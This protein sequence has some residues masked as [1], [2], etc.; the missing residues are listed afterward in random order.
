MEPKNTNPWLFWWEHTLSPEGPRR[1][2]RGAK[3]QR[4]LGSAAFFGCLLHTGGA[5]VPRSSDG[6]RSTM[7]YPPVS[8]MAMENRRFIGDGSIKTSIQFRDFPASHV[9]WN[10]RVS[11]I[12]IGLQLEH[13]KKCGFWERKPSVLGCPDSPMP[14]AFLSAWD[15]LGT[16]EVS[17]RPRLII[18]SPGHQS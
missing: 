10:Q 4:I 16:S 2:C 8:S 17:F 18:R 12:Q 7:V 15:T 3:S 9:W 13:R 14:G 5:V 1:R 6:W 11:P